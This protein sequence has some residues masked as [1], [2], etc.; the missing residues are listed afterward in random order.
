MY[1]YVV[2]EVFDLL[3]NILQNELKEEKFK[4]YMHLPEC[5]F[6][7]VDTF[8]EWNLVDSNIMTHMLWM[9]MTR[10]YFQ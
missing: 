10:Y 1:C 5:I 2:S 7:L 3:L 6:E 9:Y 8:N 4:L